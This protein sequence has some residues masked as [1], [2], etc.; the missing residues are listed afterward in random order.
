M[1]TIVTRAIARTKARAGVKARRGARAKRAGNPRIG[2]A[3]EK[4]PDNRHRINRLGSW[5]D[6]GV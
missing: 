1:R 4:G 2:L 6:F 5:H 3:R